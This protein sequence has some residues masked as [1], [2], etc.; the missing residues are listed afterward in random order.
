[1]TAWKDAKRAIRGRRIV[2]VEAN[3]ENLLKDLYRRLHVS[4]D[5]QN[6]I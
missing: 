3:G 1:M 6:S 2:E 5:D 4:P